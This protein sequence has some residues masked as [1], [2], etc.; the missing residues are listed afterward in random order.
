M[1]ANSNPLSTESAGGTTPTSN[2][3]AVEPQGVLIDDCTLPGER[4]QD[5]AFPAHPS[6]MQLSHNRWLVLCATRGV[7]QHDDDRSI[8]YQLRADAVTGP[9]LKEAFFQQTTDDWEPFDDGAKYVCLLRH[10]MGFGVPKGAIINGRLAPHDNHF[11]ALWTRSAGGRLDPATGTYQYESSVHD[12]TL[13]GVWCQFRLNEDA[14]DIEIIQAPTKLRQKGF[15]TGP[16]FCRHEQAKYMITSLV[17]PVPFDDACKEWAMTMNLSGAMAAIKFR[18]N[19]EADLYEWVE[20]GP[21]V[22][23]N[24]EFS[25]S[26]PA[27]AK[28]DDAWIIGVRVR[29]IA[30]Q[31][32]P[33]WAGS[34]HRDCGHTGWI[35]TADPFG[36]M[37]FPSIVSDPNRQAPMTL[38]RCAD[39]VLRMFSGDFT[40]SPYQQRRDPLYCWDVNPE[41]FSVTNRQVLF[42]SIAASVFPEDPALPRSTC[43]ATVPPHA[44][45]DT[46]CIFHRVMCFRYLPGIAGEPITDEL[47]ARHGVYH[48]AIRYK[49]ALPA[50]WQF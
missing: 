30:L 35:R 42:D 5:L 32:G 43:F 47:L 29:Q 12:S 33:D 44:G 41:D 8:V 2:I 46:Q 25:L 17:P 18:Y 48:T 21:T 38:F 39:G 27:L 22:T 11:V 14:S 50:T 28:A 20:T 34:R 49:E 1:N 26:E 4:K 7:R 36:D 6:A 15:E 13:E 37:S 19:H 10:P 40:N 9:V 24:D 3:A 23:G 31:R 16:A 45:G